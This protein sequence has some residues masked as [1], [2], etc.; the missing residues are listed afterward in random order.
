MNENQVHTRQE[1]IKRSCL[2]ESKALDRY[3]SS[4]PSKPSLRKAF[5][6]FTTITSRQCCVLQPWRKPYSY[7]EII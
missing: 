1:I 6:N 5:F 4:V 7:L 3:A 2:M